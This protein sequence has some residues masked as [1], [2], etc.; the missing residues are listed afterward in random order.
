MAWGRYSMSCKFYN[1]LNRKC[2]PADDVPSLSDADR[3]A[4]AEFAAAKADRIA[5][6]KAAIE[7]RRERKF[8]LLAAHQS[9]E[10]H[11]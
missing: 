10:P 5:Q 3:D 11:R 2:C 9:S 4:A 1:K 7:E 6:A 8:A